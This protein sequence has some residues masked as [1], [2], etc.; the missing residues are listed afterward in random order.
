MLHLTANLLYWMITLETSLIMPRYWSYWNLI[1]L[2]VYSGNHAPQQS[3]LE[4]NIHISGLLFHAKSK[5]DDF[6]KNELIKNNI[7]TMET[8]A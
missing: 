6:R 1:D 2:L 8:G 3:S 4:S 5:N 7:M